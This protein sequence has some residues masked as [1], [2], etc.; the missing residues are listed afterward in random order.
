MLIAMLMTA[1]DG[2]STLD[3]ATVI[4]ALIAG[5]GSGVIGAFVTTATQ[6]R[7]A[8]NAAK[9]EASKA[10]WG[11]HRALHDYALEEELAVIKD[12]TTPFTKTTKADI[13]T[14]R[15]AAYPYRMYLGRKHTKLVTQLWLP[16]YVPGTDPLGPSDAVWKWAKDLEKRLN[17]VF[18]SQN[19]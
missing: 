18:W 11:L 14:A 16:E 17:W 8:R 13:V 6:R 12:G 19:R 3:W 2:N 10:L 15:A 9:R 4:V 7:L 1:T 5:L